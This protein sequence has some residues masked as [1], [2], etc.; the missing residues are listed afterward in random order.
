MSA[1]VAELAGEKLRPS[2]WPKAFLDVAGTWEGDFP[3]ISDPP[4]EPV[5]LK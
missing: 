5:D 3:E 2:R 4:P 1:Y